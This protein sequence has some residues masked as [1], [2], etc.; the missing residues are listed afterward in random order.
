M[1]KGHQLYSPWVLGQYE[2]SRDFD[3]N[4]FERDRTHVESC[5]AI[6]ADVSQP[7][8]GVGMEIMTAYYGKKKIILVAKRG[9][10]ITRMLLHMRE[11]VLIEFDDE[12]DLRRKLAEVL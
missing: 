1:E 4:I 6:V 9:S 7:S 8:I 2:G 5:D 11:K 12:G 10:I 3:I